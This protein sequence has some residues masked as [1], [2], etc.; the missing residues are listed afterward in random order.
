MK[1]VFQCANDTPIQVVHDEPRPCMQLIGA[2][3]TLVKTVMR[4]LIFVGVLKTVDRQF[5]TSVKLSEFQ[6]LEFF[7]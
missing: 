5:T 2:L 3:L 6:L 1:C 4:I 7:I